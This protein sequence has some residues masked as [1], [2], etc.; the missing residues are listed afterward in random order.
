[1]TKFGE[2]VKTRREELQIGQEQLGNLCGVSRAYFMDKQH[3]REK[4]GQKK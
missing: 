4:F 1:M 3:V 2:K